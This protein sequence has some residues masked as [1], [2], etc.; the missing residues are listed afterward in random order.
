MIK[1][2]KGEGPEQLTQ[3]GTQLLN[4][5][6][7]DYDND[8]E[9][10][11]NG[12]PTFNFTQGCYGSSIVKELLKQRQYEK[13]CYSE[14][15][16]NGDYGDVEHFRPKGRLDDY[17]TKEKCFPGYYW[18]A[19]EWTN[20][21]LCKERINIS[22]KKNFFP[23]LNEAQRNRNHH[24]T[25]IELPYLIDPSAEDPRDHIRFHEDEPMHLSERGRVTIEL[26]GLRHSDFAE[27]RLRV[28]KTLRTMKDTVDL[29]HN[30]GYQLTDPRIEPLINHLR[31]AVLPNA[32]F[33]SMA[34]DFLSGWPHFE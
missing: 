18:L 19:Y 21:F 24:N 30:D 32:E 17:N 7:S 1:I 6:R 13:C 33:S 10:Y 4:N 20:L 27:G 31:S 11:N 25:N 14:A 28:L 34:I 9:G 15:K 26:L 23:L 12:E 5:L 8:P 16:F 22:Y 29:L 3:T 2:D